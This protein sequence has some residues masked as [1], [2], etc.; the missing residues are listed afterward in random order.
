[1]GAAQ[2]LA[3][4]DGEWGWGLVPALG[5]GQGCGWGGQTLGSTGDGTAAILCSLH[6]S[7][8]L[9]QAPPSAFCGEKQGQPHGQRGQAGRWSLLGHWLLFAVQQAPRCGRGGGQARDGVGALTAEALAER[10]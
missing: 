5:G 9:V 1:M 7:V 6:C 10:M 8:Q 4:M 3:V 2:G